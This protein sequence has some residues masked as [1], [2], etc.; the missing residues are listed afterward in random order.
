MSI[1]MRQKKRDE[2]ITTSHAKKGGV[3]RK[4]HAAQRCRSMDVL[5]ELN[6]E[7]YASSMES[8][9]QAMQL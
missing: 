2:Q 9:A 4:E 1:G 7:D 6:K 8:K 5:K 3:C